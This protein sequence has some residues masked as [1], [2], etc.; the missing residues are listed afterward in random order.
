MEKIV[1]IESDSFQSTI[2]V[3]TKVATEW[4]Q[5][6]PL[7]PNQGW[8]WQTLTLG[9]S[10]LAHSYQK[11]GSYDGNMCLFLM[12]SLANQVRPKGDIWHI[13]KKIMNVFKLRGSRSLER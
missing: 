4:E 13:F 7:L 6:T 9:R 11:Q 8:N 1:N 12:D 10:H 5:K 2:M 3:V